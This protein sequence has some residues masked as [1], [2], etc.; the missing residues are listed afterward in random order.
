MAERS[1]TNYDH[2]PMITTDPL[3]LLL[4]PDQ[5]VVVDQLRQCCISPS[6]VQAELLRRGWLTPLQV[7]WLARGRGHQLV[8]GS[9]VLLDRLGKGGMGQVFLARHRDS[10]QKVALKVARTSRENSGRLKERF[11]REVRLVARLDHP[12]VVRAV[13]AGSHHGLLYLAMEYVPGPD[14]GRL[15]RD[16][17]PLAP[18]VAADY[19]RQAALGLQHIHDRGL[20]HRDVKPNNLAL[21]EGGSVVKVLDIGLARLEETDTGEPGLTRVG[22]LLGSPDYVAPEQATNPRKAGPAADQYALGCTLY[23][24]LTGS[25]PFPGGSPL[26]KVMCHRSKEPAPMKGV[27]ADLA[28]VVS[29]LM[30]KRRRDRFA[31]A[32]E[33]AEALARHTTG[34]IPWQHAPLALRLS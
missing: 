10:D 9:Y 27:P 1:T 5:R 18:G 30:A 6:D 11:E 26:E 4:T 20:V 19:G 12:N 8:V 21:A 2:L 15:I 29:K 25:V 22:K 32:G 28:E 33:A 16:G 3:P 31:S 24:L 7:R 34:A 23:H 14:L 13:G 17:R